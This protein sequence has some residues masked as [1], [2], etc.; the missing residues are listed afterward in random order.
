MDLGCCFGQDLRHLALD[1]APTKNLIGLDIDD[2]FWDMSY[3]LFNDRGRFE[4]R[5]IKADILQEPG[6]AANDPLAEFEGKI[7]VIIASFFLHL[8]TWDGHN[9]ALKRMIGLSR[10]G[11]LIVGYNIGRPEGKAGELIVG[12]SQMTGPSHQNPYHHS[13]ETFK[14]VWKELGEETGTKW[15]VDARWRPLIGWGLQK[16]DTFWMGPDA[17]GVE[18]A[19]T[20]VA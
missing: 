16:A 12:D 3:D 14:A 2:E 15:E 17:V 18:F 4:A 5:F 1:G 13:P 9:T 7:D 19:A 6:A 8:F 20:R 11:S 10:P